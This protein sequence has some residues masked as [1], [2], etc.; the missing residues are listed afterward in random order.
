MNKINVTAAASQV[1]RISLEDGS[2]FSLTLVYKPMQRGWF[3]SEL[4]YKSFFIRGLRL[5]THP[6][7]LNQL[8]NLIP[9][10]LAVGTVDGREPLLQ[11]DFSSGN[12]QL[13][14]LT[15][16]EVAEVSELFNG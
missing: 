5:C 1:Q 11:E 14:L 9:F 13:L 7:L 16:A 10:G 12:A 4:V 15:A 3:I 2:S 8:E 6:N